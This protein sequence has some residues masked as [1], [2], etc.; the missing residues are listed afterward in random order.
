MLTDKAAEVIKSKSV[1]KKSSDEDS[2]KE[3]QSYK[4]VLRQQQTILKQAAKTRKV[5]A[6][7]VENTK[8]VKTASKNPKTTKSEA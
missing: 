8:T 5:K 4:D 1:K 2:G 3:T 7:T 6:E